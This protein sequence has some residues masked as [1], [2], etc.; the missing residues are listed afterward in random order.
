M[1]YSRATA[2]A[3]LHTVSQHFSRPSDNPGAT[4]LFPNPQLT[5]FVWD[6]ARFALVWAALHNLAE[7]GVIGY[8]F[9]KVRRPSLLSHNG[10]CA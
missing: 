3:A 8:L 9:F 4:F 6:V 7:W 2:H 5:R 10:E 1:T